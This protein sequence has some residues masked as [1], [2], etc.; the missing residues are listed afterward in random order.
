A[1]AEGAHASEQFLHGKGFGQVI[2]RAELQAGDPVVDCAAR[3][4]EQD[5]TGQMF[6]AQPFQDVEPVDAGQA[7]VEDDEVEAAA[8]RLVQCR[9]AVANYLGM[10]ASLGER[11]GDLPGDR[12]FV[13]NNQDAHGCGGKCACSEAEGKLCGQQMIVVMGLGRLMLVTVL[14]F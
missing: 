5:T 6:G 4:E 1:A 7:N 2:I 10:V 11:G 8:A 12:S 13:F 14:Q 9:F 3:G